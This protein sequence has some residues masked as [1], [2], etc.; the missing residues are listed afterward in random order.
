M[1]EPVTLPDRPLLVLQPGTGWA[2]LDLADV[3][4]HRELL[5]FLTL[6]DIKLRYK[7]TALGVVW[8]VIQPLFPM[9]VFTLFFG[10]LAKMPS[11]GVPYA[12]FAYAGLLPWTYFANAVATSAGSV[13]GSSNLVTKVYFP[14]MIIPAAAVLAA[15]VD[16]VLAFLLLIVLIAWYRMPVH[17]SVVALLPLVVLETVLALAFGL[18]FAGLT[19]KYRDVRHALPFLIQVWMFVT[20]IIFPSSIVP[21]R[22]RLVLALNP[23]M[24]VIEN[25]KA[26]LFGQPFH[27]SE[28]AFS[29]AA[30]MALLVYAAYAFRRLERTFADTI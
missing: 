23:L 30:A 10:R 12:V 13:I 7:Q 29:T 17:L 9:I 16:F 15:L 14:R 8:A 18:L 21:P 27:W 4:A 5:F 2:S 11:D 3:W 20:P 25:F 6:R 24:G 19:V 28:L 1:A 26:A 22:W